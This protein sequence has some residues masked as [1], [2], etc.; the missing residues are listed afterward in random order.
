MTKDI[1][2][3]KICPLEQRMKIPVDVRTSPD[4]STATIIPG[5][6][7]SQLQH[8]PNIKDGVFP[9]SHSPHSID[10]GFRPGK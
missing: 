4:I 5:F 10:F 7:S 8:V 6:S 9:S 2:M 1:N 3:T